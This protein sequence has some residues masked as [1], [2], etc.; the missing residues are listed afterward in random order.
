MGY[1]RACAG[2]RAAA[3]TTHL[4]ALTTGLSYTPYKGRIKITAE[5]VTPLTFY[6]RDVNGNFESPRT[7]KVMIDRKPPVLGSVASATYGGTGLVKLVAKDT[8]CGVAAIYYSLD[9]KATRSV[10]GSAVSIKTGLGSHKVVFWA[11]DKLG[12]VSAKA[13]RSW[14][15]KPLAKLSTPSTPGTVT[16]GT[17]FTATGV[18]QPRHSTRAVVTIRTY[19]ESAG[20]WVAGPTY[21]V[22]TTNT[23]TLSKWTKRLTLPSA[24]RWR[25][26]AQHADATHY[27]SSSWPRY[28]KCVAPSP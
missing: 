11:K 5:G 18:L 15:V 19:R 14:L 24:G 8:G 10:A 17:A 25:I 21:S 22:Y 2:D 9:G 27:L 4:A 7:V 6:S 26:V 12:H 1:R 16:V 3:S 28:V 13:S 20:A 23:T